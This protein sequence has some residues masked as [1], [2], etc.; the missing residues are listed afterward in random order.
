MA[1][2]PRILLR[3]RGALRFTIPFMFL[4]L[5]AMAATYTAASCNYSDVNAVINGPTHT[6][7]DGDII[8]IP[9]GACT[10]TSGLVGPSHA[11]YTLTGSGTPQSGSGS[12]GAASS[13]TATEIIDNA[14]SSAALISFSV[15]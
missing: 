4:S 1:L 13:C 6:A 11:G 15:A 5:P 12:T 3:E 2:R 10:W 8:I 14:G 9:S 7:V